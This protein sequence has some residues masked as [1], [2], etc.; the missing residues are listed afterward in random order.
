MLLFITCTGARDDIPFMTLLPIPVP[1]S[2][3]SSFSRKARLS[4]KLSNTR[5]GSEDAEEFQSAD[6]IRNH[7]AISFLTPELIP[8]ISKRSIA[9]QK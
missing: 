4:A 8:I 5:S 7:V 6:K 2:H 9:E 3:G 1:L